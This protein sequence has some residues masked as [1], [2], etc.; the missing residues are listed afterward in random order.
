[1]HFAHQVRLDGERDPRR[2]DFVDRAALG[3]GLGAG[4]DVGPAAVGMEEV[5]G[6]HGRCLRAADAEAG[7]DV[8]DGKSVHPLRISSMT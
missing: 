6:E 8:E 7:N 1:M 4:D 5:G 3:A 2:P